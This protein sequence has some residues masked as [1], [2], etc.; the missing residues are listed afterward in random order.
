M[1]D[2]SKRSPKWRKKERIRLRIRN[3]IWKL[4]V[5]KHYSGKIPRC[6]KCKIVDVRFLIIDH[7][8]GGGD[9]ERKLHGRGSMFYYWLIK[10]NFPKGYRVLCYY[11][12]HVV[13]R[14]E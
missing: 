14:R 9:K 13:R 6:E 7:I 3:F 2:Y 10:S 5:L 12:N 4:T 8:H 11:C 1:S